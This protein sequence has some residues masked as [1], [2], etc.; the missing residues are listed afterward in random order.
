[1]SINI[2][3]DKIPEAINAIL[4]AE[5]ITATEF[6]DRAGVS[7]P[8]MNRLVRGES[9]PSITTF[10]KLWPFIG[11]HLTDSTHEVAS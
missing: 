11:Q 6:A 7:Q 10:K 1:M 4:A 5:S 8:A 2:K 3:F 9:L